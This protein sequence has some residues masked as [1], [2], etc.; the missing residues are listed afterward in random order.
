MSVTRCSM[1]NIA[2]NGTLVEASGVLAQ[3]DTE[4]VRGILP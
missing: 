4:H 2:M 1:R 3:F